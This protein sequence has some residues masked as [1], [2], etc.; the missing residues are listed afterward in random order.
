VGLPACGKSTPHV[1]WYKTKHEIELIEKAGDPKLR[2]KKKSL[3]S[4]LIDYGIK[5][6][7]VSHLPYLDHSQ[8][9][10]QPPYNVG[11]RMMISYAISY[12]VSNLVD[13]EG[14]I[15][16]LK[17]EKIWDHVSPKEKEYLNK[18]KPNQRTLVDMSWGIESVWYWV[19]V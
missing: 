13:R 19:G 14:I 4:R 8:E 6:Y 7:R 2:A 12:S 1:D 3:E 16:W 15:E 5:N 11:C 9:E 17:C 10:F 18:V